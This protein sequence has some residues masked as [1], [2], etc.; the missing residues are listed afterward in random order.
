M[1]QGGAHRKTKQKLSA[2][3]V[4]ATLAPATAFTTDARAADP[5]SPQSEPEAPASPERDPWSGLYVGGH[6]GY[7]GGRSN[8]AG[9][10]ASGSIGLA[11]WFGNVPSSSK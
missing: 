7:A 10:D 9:P 1:L 8:W 4:L 11:G 5:S 3:V 6:M 2:F